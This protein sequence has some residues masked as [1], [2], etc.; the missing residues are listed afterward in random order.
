[1]LK[2]LELC[3]FKSFADRTRFDFPEGITV[4]VGPN[5][6]GKSNIV[7]AMKWVLGSQSAKSL[8]GEEMSDV[9]FKGSADRKAAG[10]A[11]ATIVFD[12]QRHILPLDSDEVHVTRR[13][14][15]SGESEYL[16]N[17]APC[18]LKDIRDLLRGSGIG[19]DGYSLIEQGKVDRMLQANPRDRRSFFEEAAGISRFKAKKV[20]ADRRLARVEQN[21]A[22][23]RDIVDEVSGRLENLKAQAS[24]AE[25]YRRLNQRM[26]ELRTGLAWTEWES[27]SSQ[28]PPLVDALAQAQE[29][30][31]AADSEHAIAI[32]Q[33]QQWDIQL[34]EIGRKAQSV[35][36]KQTEAVRQIASLQATQQSDCESRHQLEQGIERR[37]VRLLALQS[38][39][40]ATGLKLRDVLLKVDEARAATQAADDDL[41]AAEVLHGH[42]L[43]Q[44]QGAQKELRQFEQLVAQHSRDVAQWEN[45]LARHRAEKL[46]AERAK[47]SVDERLAAAQ[48]SVAGCLQQVAGCETRLDERDRE[49]SRLVGALDAEEVV[50]ADHRRLLARR[51]EEIAALQS[52]WH[53]VSERLTVLDELERRREGVTSGVK[54]LLEQVRRDPDGWGGEIRGMAADLFQAPVE[55][56]PL[57]DATLG[58]LAQYIIVSGGTLAEAIAQGKIELPGRIG[59]LRLDRI[60]RSRPGDRIRLDGL[61]GVIGRADRLVEADVAYQEIARHLLGTTWLVESLETALRFSRLCSA[62]LRFVTA[63]CE[64]LERDGSMILGPPGMA[65]GLV[66]RKSELLAARQEQEQYRFQ[67]AQAEAEVHRLAGLVDQHDARFQQLSQEH[68]QGVTQRAAEGAMLVAA[69][70]R[71]EAAVHLQQQLERQVRQTE[72]ECADASKQAAQAEASLAETRSAIDRDETALSQA[73]ESVDRWQGGLELASGNLMRSRMEQSQAAQRFESLDGTASQLRRDETER[74]AAVDDLR[75]E[76]NSDRRRLHEIELRML[77]GTSLLAEA[78]LLMEACQGELQ[79]FAMEMGKL[80]AKQRGVQKSVDKLAQRVQSATQ[81]MH[82]CQRAL[83]GVLLRRRT[84][85]DRLKEDYQL[86]L[87]M[88]QPPEGFVP[89][90]DCG[91]AEAEIAQC[92]EALLNTGA[93]NMEALQELEELQGRFDQLHGQYQDLAN[94]KQSIERVIMRINVDSRRM[95]LETLEA[96]RQNFQRLYR[97]SF[98]GGSADLVL[99]QTEDPLEAGVEIVATPPGKSSFAN[100][101]LSGGEKALTAVALL[102]A[103]FEFRPSPFCVL[104]EVDA[105]FDEANIGRF[106]TVLNEFLDRTKFVV[107]THSKKTMTAANTLYGVTMQQSGISTKVSVRFEEASDDVVVR[108]A[109]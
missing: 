96:I 53:G 58:S 77:R 29:A 86:D 87:E 101:L 83:D 7:D 74:R 63:R 25:R 106:V 21:L 50:L 4:V 75:E 94:A 108:K 11:E 3:G 81:S 45:R 2:A 89:I 16:L 79:H 78:H 70:D 49:I 13:I 39:V 6:S 98:G 60:P 82:E 18:R 104:D 5:G 48:A 24:K 59:L 107:V 38:Q 102:M 56:A 95:F 27:L 10:A 109:A 99:E 90:T 20:E 66:S 97:K 84:L 42:A 31:S 103:I 93:V 69:Q 22:R 92:R 28:L 72:Q 12:N 34:Q 52:R 33:R 100:S 51:R 36:Q 9:I 65:A 62:G 71:Y 47:N 17:G 88:S 76:V 23:L 67:L 80:R 37:G 61:K 32:E 85:A 40:T 14:Y 68:R 26:M 1:M 46:A 30:H 35:E 8:R 43:N 41:E 57:I 73:R 15:R 44:L 64:L 19:F 105:P 55:L 91:A 54:Y